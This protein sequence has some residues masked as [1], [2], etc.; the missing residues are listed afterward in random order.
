MGEQVTEVEILSAWVQKNPFS[1][2]WIRNQHHKTV[3]LVSFIHQKYHD[4]QPVHRMVENLMVLKWIFS[5]HF[6]YE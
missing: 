3:Y 2:P 1:T 6:V 5:T 4:L